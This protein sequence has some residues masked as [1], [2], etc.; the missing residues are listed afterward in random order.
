M[1]TLFATRHPQ[2]VRKLVLLAPALVLIDY[3]QDFKL[4]LQVPCTIIQGNQDEIVPMEETRQLATKFFSHLE[5][6]V[7]D[8]D[9]RLHKTA[10]SLDWEKV[11]E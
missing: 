9:H 4:P 10:E 2:Q 8:D 7:V 3:T 11:L 5:F 6:I 1:A